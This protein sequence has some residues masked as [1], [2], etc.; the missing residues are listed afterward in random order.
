MKPNK[1]SSSIFASFKQASTPTSKRRLIVDEPLHQS[2]LTYLDPSS[3]QRHTISV[4]SPSG[5]SPLGLAQPIPNESRA[6]CLSSI[7]CSEAEV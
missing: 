3:H 2:L 1:P 4:R 6:Y 7:G 5:T